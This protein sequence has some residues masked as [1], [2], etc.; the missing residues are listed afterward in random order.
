MRSPGEEE[1]RFAR[2][3]IPSN[4]PR[5]VQMPGEHVFLPLEALIAQHL[6]LLF[7]GMEI[8]ESSAFRVTRNADVERN[9]E[10]AEDLLE[11]IEAELRNRKF[12]P[13][14]RLEIEA[15]MSEALVNWLDDAALQHKVGCVAE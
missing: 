8:I 6:D 12:A 10:E 4:R 1:N 2:V 5:F 3:K 15:G 9:E 14:V 11:N 7:V 13:I